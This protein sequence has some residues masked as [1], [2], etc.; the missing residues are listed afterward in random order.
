MKN[1]ITKTIADIKNDI[2]VYYHIPDF[3]YVEDPHCESKDNFMVI[4]HRINSGFASFEEKVSFFHSLIT[5]DYVHNNYFFTIKEKFNAKYAEW[6][7]D[8]ERRGIFS[9]FDT[10][11]AVMLNEL[12]VSFTNFMRRI[13]NSISY[14]LLQKDGLPKT[15]FLKT[16][17]GKKLN[18]LI[19]NLDAFEN[20]DLTTFLQ[21]VTDREYDT[22][23]DEVIVPE[24]WDVIVESSWIEFT[25]IHEEKVKQINGYLFKARYDKKSKSLD[26]TFE[27]ENSDTYNFPHYSFDEE[28]G[29]FV[30]SSHELFFTEREAKERLKDLI[31]EHEIK[32]E[33][34]KRQLES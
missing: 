7:G 25:N 10:A 16:V 33:E 8:D 22:E 21:V 28:K 18:F 9:D 6:F 5:G 20:Q 34:M 23:N 2:G 14:K 32:L 11:K 31:I 19:S 26:I 24:N 1:T 15:L 27:L 17:V 3:L 30:F 13:E 29:I 4:W 12:N